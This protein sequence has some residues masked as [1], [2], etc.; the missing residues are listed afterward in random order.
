MNDNEKAL[1]ATQAELT[2]SPACK[3]A[4]TECTATPEAS[5]SCACAETES[6]ALD[7]AQAADAA[8]PEANAP[9]SVEEEEKKELVEAIQ[10]E[11]RLLNDTVTEGTDRQAE[12]PAADRQAD[13]TI[14]YHTF[15][16]S[17]L[18]EALRR[19]V[20]AADAAAH[21]KVAAIKQSFY[22]L[23]NR[24][25][26]AEMEEFVEA[27]NQPEAFTASLDEAEVEIKEMLA[28]FREV[29][30]DFLAREEVRRRDNLEFKLRIIAQ[31][32]ELAD[33]IDNINLHFPKFQQLQ[34]EFKDI[35]DIPAGDVADTWK[36]YQLAVEQFY[37]R[38]KMNKEL[39]DLDFKKNL[40]YKLSLIEEARTL[41]TET[42]AV[43]AFR[44]LQDLHDKW[45]ETGP[46]A[47][48]QREKIWDE[49]K[50]ISTVVNKRHQDFFEK[51][52]AAELANEEAKTALCEQ[53]EAIDMDAI[54][55]FNEW[56]RQ[57]R[58][59]LELQAEWKKLGF[60]SRKVNNMLFNRFRKV[61]DEFFARKAEFFRKTKEE[62]AANMARKVELCEK[63]EALRDAED[64]RKAMEEVS[65]LQ[66]EW[67][68]VGPVARKQ[69][70]AIWQRFQ[71]ACNFFYEA[72]KKQNAAVR[73]EENANLAAKRAIIEAL[74][75]IDPEEAERNQAVAQVRELQNQWNKT[76]HVPFRQKDA[77][78]AEY[79]QVVDALYSAL[80]MRQQ[81]ARMA[82]YQEQLE[83]MDADSAKLMRERE[84]LSRA[85]ETK[86]TEIQ[87]A[88]N[89]L[90]FFKFRSSDG[91]SML[92]DMERRI[93]RL[94]EDLEMIA[95]KISAVNEK[96]Q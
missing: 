93:D 13:E 8:E 56:D 67:R 43:A 51:R 85:Y 38:L 77:V 54:R 11:A 25:I 64:Q 89:N 49:F 57:T 52:K 63:A 36:S 72:R 7:I 31:L 9:E 21:K 53:I 79:R 70:D 59:V 16:K 83:G 6:P 65:A 84:R 46:V 15:T 22:Q 55:N 20:E 80:N 33:D 42:D 30:S 91:N 95:R 74:R 58:R 45:R 75:A 87:T 2:E 73:Q 76:G 61:C 29:R 88:E 34:Q 47:K 23:R 28:R 92:R 10:A 24:E 1:D 86:K 12:E 44:R 26:E 60:A 71:T 3:S 90:G 14:N 94:R 18:V 39:R 35:T 5:D 17:E 41:E 48:D 37:D 4:A 40:E 27:G 62:F 32:R 50:A 19:I 82:G 68:K 66:A 96:L 69:S 81:Q 78:F